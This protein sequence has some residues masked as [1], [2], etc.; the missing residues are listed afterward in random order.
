MMTSLKKI[1]VLLV[2][3]AT[4]SPAWS[5]IY[6][7]CK[8]KKI[9]D[10]NVATP[11]QTIYEDCPGIGFMV[12]GK[13]LAKAYCWKDASNLL[14]GKCDKPQDAVTENTGNDTQELVPM[15]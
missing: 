7:F 9:Y 5:A 14:E 10:D 12:N 8:V 11:P 3:F 15:E 1:S 13:D 2:M 6:D 4:A